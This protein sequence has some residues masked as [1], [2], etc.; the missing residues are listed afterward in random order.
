M[1]GR[2]FTKLALLIAVVYGFPCTGQNLVPNPSF[3]NFN[4]CPTSISGLDYSP[5]YNSFPTVQSWISPLQLGTADYFNTCATAN[6]GVSVPLNGFGS[7]NARTGDGYVGIIAWERNMN[8]TQAG[9]TFAEYIQCRLTQPLVAGTRYCVNFYVSNGVSNGNYNYVGIDNIG[10]NFSGVKASVA[11]GYTMSMPNSIKNLQGNFLTDTSNWVRISGVYVATGGE[12]WLT[13]GWFDNGG[14]PGFAPITPATPN[15]GLRH[16]CYLYIDDVSVTPISNSDT[17]FSRQDSL[18]CKNTGMAI[19]LTSKV[20]LADY[21]W[22]NGALTRDIQV[23]D[24][25]TFWCVANIGCITYV[26]TFVIRADTTPALSLGKERINCNSQSIT[27]RPNYKAS[28]Y[29]WS[30]GSRADSIMV[31]TSGTYTLT[32][33][34]R[35]GIQTDTVSV[36]IQPPTVPPLVAD[37]TICQF[38]NNV[39]INVKDTAI[40]W[41]T[42]RDGNIG[43]RI[44]PNIVSIRPGIYDLYITTTAGKCESEKST[45][46]VT[47]DYTP[48]EELG[49][50][51]IMCDNDIQVIGKQQENVTFKWNTGASTCCILPEREGLYRRAANN[52]CGSYIDS[53]W[54]FH[55]PCDDCVEFPN[56]FVPIK[57]NPNNIFRP[58]L[59]CPVSSFNMKIFNRWGNKVYES[60]DVYQGWNGRYNYEWAAV[61]VYVY[62][63]EYIAKGKLQKQVL[64]GNVTLLR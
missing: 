19:S 37:T 41:Y 18:Y 22:N 26:D 15:P 63:V 60:G 61:G 64:T 28:T 39:V 1:T 58:L 36:Y 32:V 17:V 2:L 25:G 43:S 33:T 56:A 4:R 24:T 29:L 48:H 55:K 59:N 47:I 27:I 8:P 23:K 13:L 30:T 45:A 62:V 14:N 52:E 51:E 34:N 50:R 20:Q 54:V 3:E 38:A 12:Q 5:T 49:D 46:R 9:N 16:R 21:S 31:N 44:Q 35:C 7:Q 6:S 10:V 11:T 57:D 53:I 42:R 40:T